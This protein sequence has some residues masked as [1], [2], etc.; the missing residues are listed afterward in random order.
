MAGLALADAIVARMEAMVPPEN[1]PF[2]ARTRPLTVAIGW[3]VLAMACCCSRYAPKSNGRESK[4]QLC[5]MRA[6]DA[7]AALLYC[8]MVSC[9]QLGSPVRST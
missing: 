1:V 5:T 9:I 7:L 3:P 8:A 2:M 4:P 6:P